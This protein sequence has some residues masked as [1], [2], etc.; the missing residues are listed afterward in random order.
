MSAAALR[1]S[2]PGELTAGDCHTLDT[3]SMGTNLPSKYRE[4][5]RFSAGEIFEPIP[6]TT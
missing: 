1:K 6:I 2:G 5:F 4:L 3:A